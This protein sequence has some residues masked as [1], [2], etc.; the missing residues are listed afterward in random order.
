MIKKTGTRKRMKKVKLKR[1]T[2]YELNV[3]VE[4]L[5]IDVSS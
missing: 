2:A 1:E 5:K 3:K 4:I